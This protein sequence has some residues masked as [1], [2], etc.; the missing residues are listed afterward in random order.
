MHAV[1]I[2]MRNVALFS[3][4]LAEVSVLLSV[5]RCG[6][7]K[8]KEPDYPLLIHHFNTPAASHDPV[9]LCVLMS[10]RGESM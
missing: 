6:Q 7:K 2:Q 1:R 9:R 4:G 10:S 8:P 5:R 3:L